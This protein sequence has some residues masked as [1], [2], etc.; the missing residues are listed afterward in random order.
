MNCPSGDNDGVFVS[1]DPPPSKS[2]QLSFPPD[3]Q[4]THD[5]MDPSKTIETTVRHNRW[6]RTPVRP[7][8]AQL[9]VLLESGAHISAAFRSRLCRMNWG[10]QTPISQR[11]GWAEHCVWN[12]FTI[13]TLLERAG[14]RM[15]APSAGPCLSGAWVSP[16]RRDR[17]PGLQHYGLRRRSR[18][19]RPSSS[20]A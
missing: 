4:G 17:H 3:F 8:I 10:C 2:A 14:L 18:K 15:G 20:T 5:A 6:L 13:K 16:F 1:K 11:R 9:C 12:P 7:I 19:A